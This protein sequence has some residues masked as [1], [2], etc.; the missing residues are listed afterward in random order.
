M[1]AGKKLAG[2]KEPATTFGS[3]LKIVG[4]KYIIQPGVMD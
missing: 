1:L 3:A 4:A 2:K